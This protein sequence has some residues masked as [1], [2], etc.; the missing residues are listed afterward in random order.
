MDVELL[1][2]PRERIARLQDIAA[3]A[4]LAV[5][6]VEISGDAGG[7]RRIALSGAATARAMGMRNAAVALGCAALLLAVTAAA[8][9]FPRP[10]GRLI[11]ARA[12]RAA[13][14][15]KGGAGAGLRP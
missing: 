12:G 6:A 15:G 10:A 5:D 4:G 11:D 13:L 3:E 9:P 2:I 7:A 14:R 1:L 8:L